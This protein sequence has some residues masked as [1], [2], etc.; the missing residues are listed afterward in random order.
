MHT[1]VHN[2]TESSTLNK[3]YI[4]HFVENS[5]R[6][7]VGFTKPCLLDICHGHSNHDHIAA[8]KELQQT[9]TKIHMKMG[10]ALVGK[11]GSVVLW[12]E[13]RGLWWQCIIDTSETDK[14]WNNNI[15]MYRILE[16][17]YSFSPIFMFTGLLNGTVET[18][19]QC[20]LMQ[21]IVFLTCRH[22]FI[23]LFNNL[24]W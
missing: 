7:G 5:Q 17:V 22:A 18:Q 10:V 13:W 23:Y 11:K 8:G 21:E 3:S 6:T 24:H 12:R 2:I 14:M 9:C 15:E 19:T 20:V 4:Q 16:A 1:T